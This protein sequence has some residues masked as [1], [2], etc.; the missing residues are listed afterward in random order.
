MENCCFP[1]DTYNLIISAEV[2][3]VKNVH[4]QGK[5]L[6]CKVVKIVHEFS[7]NLWLKKTA[8]W[9]KPKQVSKTL[10]KALYNILYM[11]N[12]WWVWRLSKKIFKCI[13]LAF[14]ANDCFYVN[15]PYLHIES[16]RRHSAV[17]QLVHH[18]VCWSYSYILSLFSKCQCL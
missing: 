3:P 1:A 4:R 6:F 11:F 5:I 9:F 17:C 8:V 12:F 18:S 16:C 13:S 10:K 14:T 2:F 15:S 7:W